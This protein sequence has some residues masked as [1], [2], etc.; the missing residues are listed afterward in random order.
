MSRHL[1]GGTGVPP[2]QGQLRLHVETVSKNKDVR[3]MAV[4]ISNSGTREVNA[5]VGPVFA[6]AG[7]MA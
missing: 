6:W 5:G 1:G 2:V 7:E 3:G 4:P